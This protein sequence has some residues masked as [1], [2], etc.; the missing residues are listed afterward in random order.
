M[1]RRPAATIALILALGALFAAGCSGASKDASGTAE[2]SATAVSTS[3][4]ADATGAARDGWKTPITLPVTPVAL[5]FEDTDPKFEVLP[6]ARA[7]YGEYSGG[8]YEIEAP[9]NWNGDVVYFAHGFRGNQPASLDA[10]SHCR[11]ARE[12]ERGPGD[13]WGHWLARAAERPG[14]CS[15]LYLVSWAPPSASPSPSAGQRGRRRWVGRGP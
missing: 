13:R 7:F 5:S 6:G 1:R 15:V 2:Q 10:H 9:D 12:M 3:V 14:Y 8:V 11:P 4:T